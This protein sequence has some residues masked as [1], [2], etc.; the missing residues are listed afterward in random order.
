MKTQQNQLE[1]L[2]KLG[3]NEEFLPLTTPTITNKGAIEKVRGVRVVRGFILLLRVFA[4]LREV[5]FEL[6]HAEARSE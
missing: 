6:F 2:G 1:A 4:S 5:H 3:M